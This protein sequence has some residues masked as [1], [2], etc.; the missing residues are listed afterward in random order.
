MLAPMEGVIE[1]YRERLPFAAQ[2]PVVSLGEGSTPLVPA[3]R[4]SERAGADVWLNLRAPTRP[5]RSK[6]A[7]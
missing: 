1:R 3:P 6:I 5:D 2:D 4:L 7:G